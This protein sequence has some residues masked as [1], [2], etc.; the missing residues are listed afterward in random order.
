[1]QVDSAVDVAGRP[2]QRV[3]RYAYINAAVQ[4][5][6]RNPF[7]EALVANP[8]PDAGG[9]SKVAELPYD[10][11]RRR[12]SV[13]VDVDDRRL[14][15]TLGAPE[16]VLGVCGHLAG[17]EGGL[18]LDAEQR[19]SADALTSE[20]GAKG[21]RVLGVATR[22]LEPG[23]DAANISESGLTLEGLVAFSDPPRADVEVALREL[24]DDGID[25]KILTGDAEAVTRHV[26]EA[27]GLSGERIMT[28][29]ELDGL[30]E[31]Q[32]LT[33]LSGVRVFARM[34]PDQKLHVIHALQRHSD[35]DG[36]AHGYFGTCN[37]Q[38]FTARSPR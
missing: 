34:T 30:T 7:D 3:L 15:I 21:L 32:L 18:P 10:F 23:T 37:S 5:G 17:P 6:Y 9:F 2:S 31:A 35:Q 22:V 24:H 19:Q 33:V 4:S 20:L 8:P 1:M 11:Q 13:V 25:L 16:S 12:L 38:C 14:L 27:I 28:G 26:C 36:G 29:D